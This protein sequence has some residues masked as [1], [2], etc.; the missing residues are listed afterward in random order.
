MFVCPLIPQ[1]QEKYRKPLI[2]FSLADGSEMLNFVTISL[3]S[4]TLQC[5]QHNRVHLRRWP[6]NAA[7]SRMTI[8]Y[9]MEFTRMSY[10]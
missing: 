5:T 7:T 10:N 8:Y 6:R 2:W 4:A 3:T 9:Q 1:S